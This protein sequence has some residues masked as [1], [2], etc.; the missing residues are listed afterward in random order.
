VKA[1]VATEHATALPR[2]QA[3]A[4]DRQPAAGAPAWLRRIEFAL[5]IEGD[6]IRSP[7]LVDATRVA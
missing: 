7:G 2:P 3:G 4:L 1:P 6:A 5:P